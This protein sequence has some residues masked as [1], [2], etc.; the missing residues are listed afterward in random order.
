M[1]ER[2]IAAEHVGLGDVRAIGRVGTMIGRLQR[3]GVAL[4]VIV[5]CQL[6]L[7][8]DGTVVNIALPKIQQDLHFSATGLSW[9]ISAYTLTFGGLLLL[10]GRAGDILGRRRVFVVGIG[11]FTLASLLGGLAPT[12]ELL[13]A[14]RALQGIGAA[15]AAP[16]TLAL[17]VTTFAEGPER[18]RAIG[19]YSTIAPIGGGARPIPRGGFPPPPSLRRGLLFQ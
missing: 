12:A 6:M 16:S 14:A 3:T 1:T 5:T 10:G 17:I 19:I 9:V 11:L 8:L 18:N 4:A 15:I 7:I 13:L 2:S